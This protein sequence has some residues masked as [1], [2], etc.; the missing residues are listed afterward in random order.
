MVV[1]TITQGSDSRVTIG[2]KKDKCKARL[3]LLRDGDRWYVRDF[4]RD[5]N[6][7]LSESCCEKREWKSHKRLDPY[8]L[9]VIRSLH[10]NNVTQTKIRCVVGSMF[11]SLQDAPCTKR[12]VRTICNKIARKKMD[13]DV[14]KTV[15]LF[16]QMKADDP[17][18]QWSAELGPNNTIQTLMWC[19]GK[20][21]QQYACLGDVITFDTTY[22]TNIYKMPFGLFVGVNNHFQTIIFAGVLMKYETTES[23]KWVFNEFLQLM[24]GEPPQTVL[25]GTEAILMLSV[26]F[27][28]ILLYM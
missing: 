15:Q 28:E 12:S 25:T 1:Y 13:D 3:K 2:T 27:K 23:F 20:N 11:G 17:D 24:R 7:P 19:S 22:C 18:F 8:T 6:H 21:V 5:H 4:V 9:D 14:S 10:M 26:T 16:K